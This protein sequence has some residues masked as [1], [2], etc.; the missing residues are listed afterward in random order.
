MDCIYAFFTLNLL[1]FFGAMRLIHEESAAY[2][3]LVLRGEETMG[4]RLA[5]LKA[6]EDEILSMIGSYDK[7]L[8]AV[9]EKIRFYE[10]AFK[11]ATPE[12]LNLD[13]SRLKGYYQEER[14]YKA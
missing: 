14:D 7:A 6:Q 1:G 2:L 5:M 8:E 11:T 9:Q 3:E 10:D 12:S 4:E 13:N